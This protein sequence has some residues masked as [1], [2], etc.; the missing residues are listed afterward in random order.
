MDQDTRMLLNTL[1]ILLVA[2]LQFLLRNRPQSKQIM[3]LEERLAETEQRLEDVQRR[4]VG[5]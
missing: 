2:L 4:L 1:L 3:E 5:M